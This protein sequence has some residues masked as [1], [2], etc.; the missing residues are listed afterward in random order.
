VVVLASDQHLTPVPAASLIAALQRNDAAA[1]AAAPGHFAAL[2][3]VGTELRMARTLGASL[4]WFVAKLDAGPVAVVADR[5]DVI[6]DWCR[7]HGLEGQF[8]P[9]YTRMVPAHHVATM[10]LRG[11]PDPA[12]RFQR[13]APALEAGELP[14][15]L[16]LLGA[17]YVAATLGELL[18]FFSTRAAGER[19][20]VAFSGGVDST[21]V[22]LLA[23]E[24]LRRMGRD[25]A[26]VTAVTLSVDGGAD[27][28][29][30]L[31][32]AGELGLAANHR[33]LRAGIESI[34]P[35][36]AIAE[37]EDYKP[38]D[39]ACAAMMRVL[40]DALRR[41]LPDIEVLLDGDGGDENLKSYPLQDGG[42]VT[43][44]SVV[45]NPLLYQEGWGV[46]ALKHSPVY[47]G[48]LSRGIVRGLAPA[49]RRGLVGF[50]P[51]ATARVVGVAA[52]VPFARLVGEDHLRLYALKGALLGAGVQ[53]LL[54]RTLPIRDKRRFQ[55]GPPAAVQ[56]RLR[57]D[58]VW[59]RSRFAELWQPSDPRTRLN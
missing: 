55:D 1:L 36:A 16:E 19:Y 15:D 17:T 34:D 27:V 5:L 9:E 41:E 3:T 37:I 20:A 53:A 8:R 49:R 21:T 40:C 12:P 18:S 54:G 33:V 4:R 22:W 44:R 24:A 32:V 57:V 11:C 56:A 47:S 6:R 43:I 7:R 29:Q 51:F 35:A 48:G 50:S 58:E 13:F 2:A 30:A 52:R 59:C 23:R 31:E 38:L 28:E 26:A 10:D 25:P 42:E 46:G 45:A 14:A 39:V